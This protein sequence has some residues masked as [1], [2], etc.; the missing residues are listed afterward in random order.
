MIHLPSSFAISTIDGTQHN[1]RFSSTRYKLVHKLVPLRVPVATC[2]WVSEPGA[3]LRLPCEAILR[4]GHPRRQYGLW[5][6]RS[7]LMWRWC[8]WLS[9]GNDPRHTASGVS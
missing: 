1:R 8:Y 9:C 3:F 4:A 2:R 5:V 6:T 7:F